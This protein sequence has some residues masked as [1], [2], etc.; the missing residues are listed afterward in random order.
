MRRH[1]RIQAALAAAAL[2]L[3]AA[4][5]FAAAEGENWW[6]SDD[7]SRETLVS[8]GAEIPRYDAETGRYEIGSAEQLLF[9]ASTWKPEDGN[10]DGV[11]DAPCSGTYVLTADIDMAPLLASIGERISLESGEETEGWMPPIGSLDKEGEEG[12]VRCAFFGTFE[13]QGHVIRN[14]RVVRRQNKY[15]GLFGNIGHDDGVGTVRELALLDARIEA[16]ASAGLLAGAIYGDVE[17]VLCTGTLTVREK[18]AG[19]LAGK[20]KRNDEGA[21]G[22]V[23]N[24][25]VYCDI[26]V[27]GEGGEN[28]AAGLITSSQ[29]KGG[30][31][32]ACLAAG[33]VTVYGDKAETVGGIT[34]NLKGG[35]ALDDCVMLGRRIAAEGTKSSD[36]GL[37]CGSYSGDTG[38]HIHNN[39]VWEGTKLTGAMA[40]D[41]PDTPAF[42]YV[43]AED[44]KSRAFYADRAGW[45]MDGAWA[46]QGDEENGFPMLRSFLDKA[47]LTALLAEDLRIAEPV[48]QGPEPGVSRVYEGEEAVLTARALLPEGESLI[49][50]TILFG[51]GK[52]RASL[53]ESAPMAAS[54]DIL[55][56]APEG[57]AQGTY[58]YCIEADTTAGR[59]TLPA[60][61]TLRLDVRSAAERFTPAQLTISPGER[62]DAV[63]INWIT[64]AEGLTGEV[65]V[66]RAGAGDWEATFPAESY[67]AV[68]GNDHGWFMSYSADLFGLEPSAGYEYAAV[69]RDESGAEYLSA[70]HSFTTLPESGAFSFVVI[71][72]LQGTS[73][74]AYLPYLYTDGAFL[75]D[76]LHPDFVVNLGD[77]TEDDTMVEWSYMFSTIG[78]VLAERLTAYVPGNHENKGDLVYTHFKGRTNLPGGMETEPLREATSCFVVGD[79]CFVT[80]NTE[81][82]SGVP[83]ANAEA[84]KLAYYE[85][86]MAWA[87]ERFE[88]SGCR[89]RIVCA[90][91][92]LVQK[93]DAATA[94]LEKMCAELGVDLFFNGHIHTYFRASVTGDGR[95]AGDGEATAFITTSPMGTKFDDYG[96]EID[97]LLRA[98]AGGSDDPRQILTYVEVTED[99]ITVTAYRRATA[100]EAKKK[101][102]AE[103]EEIDRLVLTAAVLDAAA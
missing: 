83:G 74:E 71:S 61:G 9:L 80:L 91:A 64:E 67:A 75:K 81:P 42:T 1:L 56:G 69:T 15:A 102:C 73:E 35:M 62:Y 95:P 26:T 21:L 25:L 27:L 52:D 5:P 54:G 24:C 57:L 98:R 13:G 43:T 2:L 31:I 7:W 100:A 17:N 3:L 94:F 37:L 70:V 76:T 90:H 101:T 72:D 86:Q 38:S 32:Y 51:T 58:Y 50:G 79:A 6:E 14:L 89:W 85:E 96:G 29:S 59:L 28:G 19:G 23:R 46:W 30:R 41:H 40:S 68:V 47:D 53:T 34:G 87:K 16:K 82:Y 45:D 60:D 77:L 18:T 99:G 84:D 92:G 88:E 11:P 103:Y 48:L 33:S 8:L 20:I 22:T 55:S 65:R 78:S 10:G 4:L 97:G 66:R 39:Y 44:A 36:F 93:D 49:G 63:G 12:G